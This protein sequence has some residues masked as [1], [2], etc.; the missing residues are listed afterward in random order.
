MLVFN[1]F[2]FQYLVGVVNITVFQEE[3]HIIVFVF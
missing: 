2:N 3:I 1:Q